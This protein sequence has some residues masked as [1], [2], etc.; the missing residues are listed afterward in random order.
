MTTHQIEITEL[1]KDNLPPDAVRGWEVE[2]HRID[3]HRFHIGDVYET[4]EKKF[5]Y[6]WLHP[7]RIDYVQSEPIYRSRK[8]AI[9]ALCAY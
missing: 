6:F 2:I 3:D 9:E 1:D 7:T 4:A 5:S 8:A